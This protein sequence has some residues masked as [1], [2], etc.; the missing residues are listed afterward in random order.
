MAQNVIESASKLNPFRARPTSKFF[1]E[2]LPVLQL[3]PKSTWWVVGYHPVWFKA[4]LGAVMR[5]TVSS[6]LGEGVLQQWCP[7]INVAWKNAIPS[8]ADVVVKY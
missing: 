4:Q 7:V 3:R 8:M 1:M 2:A 5:R 6:W